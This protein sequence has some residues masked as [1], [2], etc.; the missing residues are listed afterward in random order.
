MLCLLQD[1]Q[2]ETVTSTRELVLPFAEAISPAKVANDFG[3]QI[4]KTPRPFTV[5]GGGAACARWY[6]A[7]GCRWAVRRTLGEVRMFHGHYCRLLSLR[8][9]RGLE[10][11]RG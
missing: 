10:I 6:G 11:W 4:G 2:L 5:T 1:I 3:Q 8:L 7:A 9:Q